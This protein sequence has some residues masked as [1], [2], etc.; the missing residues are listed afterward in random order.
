VANRAG[1]A[2]APAITPHSLRRTWATFRA[3]IGA[4]PTWVAA[5]IVHVNPKFTFSVY[6]QVA[7][8][9]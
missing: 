8:R 1:M 7:T 5:Q 3:M 9:R 6:Q 4:N 2:P